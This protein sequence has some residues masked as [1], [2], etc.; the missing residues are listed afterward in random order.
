MKYLV[1][2]QRQLWLHS[3]E[4]RVGIKVSMMSTYVRGCRLWTIFLLVVCYGF[5]PVKPKTRKG[6]IRREYAELD[7][8]LVER[9]FIFWFVQVR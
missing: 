2:L 1:L 6:W 8:I 5:Q 4:T 3:V 7:H 9:R